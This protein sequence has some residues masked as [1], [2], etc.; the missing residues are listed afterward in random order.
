MAEF[1]KALAITLSNEGSFADRS[2]TTGEVVNMGVTLETLRR[3]DICIGPIPCNASNI[4]PADIQYVKDLSYEDVRRVYY[5]DYWF[6]LGLSSLSDQNLANQLFDLAV[7]DGPYW[8]V[9]WLQH[10]VGVTADGQVGPQ[11][12][13]AANAANPVAV[14][15]QV[16][17][18]ATAHYNAAQPAADR[19]QWLARLARMGKI[20][21]LPENA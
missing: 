15:T 7:N 4:S 8:P 14:L 3:L 6:P 5:A 20:A 16:R 11:T 2:K 13:G 19:P 17:A 21:G 12:L 1:Q 9:A 18:F 10:A